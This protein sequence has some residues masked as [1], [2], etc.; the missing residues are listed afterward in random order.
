MPGK[1]Y[2]KILGV[3]RQATEK[4]IKQVYRKL[5]RQYH[6]DVNP[7]D[8]TAEAKFKEINEAYEVLSDPEKRKKYDQFGENW[9]YADRFEGTRQGPGAPQWEYRTQ[10]VP[11]DLGDIF[12]QSP[13]GDFFEGQPRGGFGTSRRPRRGQDLEHPVEVTLEEAFQGT[14]RLLQIQGEEACSLC[15]GTGRIQRALCSTCR[16]TGRL[17]K[18]RRLEVKIPPGVQDGS[19]VRIAGAGGVGGARGGQGDLHLVVSVR[20]HD[21]FQRKGDDLYVEVPVLLTDAILGGEVD[22]PT[23]KGKIVLTI[24]P[25]TQNGRTFRLAGQGM[26]RLNNDSRGDLLATVKVVLP[27]K[28]TEKEKE[29]FRQLRDLHRPS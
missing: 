3:S 25:E 6:P 21:Q 16:G 7:G 13:F 1:D 8:K 10:E 29:F 22:V 9:A 18:L 19:R 20:P 5:A 26:P 23:L 27:S 2:Y 11:F 24:P 17:P 4:E 15:Q 12:S 14:T 28:L